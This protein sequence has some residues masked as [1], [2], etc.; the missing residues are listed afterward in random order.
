MTNNKVLNCDIIET[1]ILDSRCVFD[2]SM[3]ENIN[4]A[5]ILVRML[6]IDDYYNKNDFGF[7]FYNEMQRTRCAFN[8]KIPPEYAEHQE[9][10]IKLINSMSR[11]YNYNYPIILN[12]NKEL[13][14]G[15][16]RLALCLYYNIKQVPV[17][18]CDNEINVDYSLDWFMR[19]GLKHFEEFILQ[20][21]KEITQKCQ[22]RP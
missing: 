17:I 3:R 6:A 21:Y 18:V 12:K 2:H 22:R 11:G 15:S 10:F 9:E 19:N 20:K 8:S 7:R 13:L 16:H 1:S 14:D 5:D 4:R